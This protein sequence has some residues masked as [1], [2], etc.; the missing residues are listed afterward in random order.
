MFSNSQMEEFKIYALK[1]RQSACA[2]IT[3]TYYS[4]FLFV[5]SFLAIMISLVGKRGDAYV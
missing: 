5:S 1:I 3:G 4:S 2:K